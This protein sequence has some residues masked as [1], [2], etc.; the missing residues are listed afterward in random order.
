MNDDFLTYLRDHL[1]GA[2]F[3]LS[4]L[5]D[6]RE[7]AAD[8]DVATLAAALHPEIEAD[9]DALERYV[10]QLGGSTGPLRQA[11]AWFAQ[12][13]SKFKLSLDE[14]LGRFEA[15]EALT[16][17]VRGKAALWSTIE[18]LGSGRTAA[19]HHVEQ[20]NFPTLQSRAQRQAEQLEQLRLKLA[21]RTFG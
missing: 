17:G 20:L 13:T 2:K 15:I 4:L 12:K 16:L 21:K 1:A 6:L 3:A 18:V 11:A 14:P 9:R 8:S 5:E 7:Q 10:D 19:N